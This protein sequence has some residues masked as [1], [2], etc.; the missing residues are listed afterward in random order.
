MEAETAALDKE[1]S[2]PRFL[3]LVALTS[4]F[5]PRPAA[6]QAPAVPG[7]EQIAQAIRDLGSPRFALREKAS[8]LLWSA[9]KTGELAL[10]GVLEN[11]ELEVARRARAILEKFRW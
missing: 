11:A 8:A 5:F 1:F 10:Y 9:G 7:K 3:A 2:M 6:A 4:L